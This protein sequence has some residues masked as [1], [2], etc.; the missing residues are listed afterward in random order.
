MK[1]GDNLKLPLERLVVRLREYNEWRRGADT[2]HPE[3]AVVG[4]DIDDAISVIE[5]HIELIGKYD[6]LQSAL[7]EMVNE[8][9][10]LG[11]D[12]PTY[13]KAVKLIVRNAQAHRRRSRP[14]Q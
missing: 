4:R 7:I 5:Q 8:P 10:P 12:R 1:G 13:Q 11:I 14:V 9:Q 2:D 6:V 3:P